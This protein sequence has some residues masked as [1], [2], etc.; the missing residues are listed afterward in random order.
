[1]TTPTPEA[2]HV[3]WDEDQVPGVPL[4]LL[5]VT[6]KGAAPLYLPAL[7]T[8]APE[9]QP[10]VAGQIAALFRETADQMTADLALF[11]AVEDAMTPPQ[12]GDVT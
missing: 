11:Q 1:V 12:G 9:Y 8:V 5:I 10:E 2:Y 4:M 6:T 3:D 7:T